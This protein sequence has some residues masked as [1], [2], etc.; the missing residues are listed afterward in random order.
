MDSTAALS[1]NLSLSSK[2]IDPGGGAASALGDHADQTLAVTATSN[3]L[4]LQ[5]IMLVKVTRALTGQILLTGGVASC[6]SAVAVTA[7]T[8]HSDH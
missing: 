6:H 7:D 8:L 1:R 3:N 5:R 2:S 4:H